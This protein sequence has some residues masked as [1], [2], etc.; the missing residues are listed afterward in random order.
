MATQILDFSE[1]NGLVLCDKP[2][3]AQ[4]SYERLYLFEA[5]K[6]DAYAVFFRRFFKS[7]EDT[8]TYKSEPSVCIFLEKQVPINSQKHLDT[9]AALWSEGK[10][11]I[12]I[13]LKGNTR[14]DIYNVRKPVEKIRGELSLKNLQL[15][16]DSIQSLIEEKFSAK[17][18]GQGTFWEQKDNQHLININKSPYRHLVDYLMKVRKKFSENEEYD[19]N[20]ETIDK[21][22]VLTILVKFLEEK[23][24]LYDDKSTLDEIYSKHSLESIE[25]IQGGF[26][27]LSIIEDMSNEFNGKIFDQFTPDEK[28]SH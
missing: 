23:K 10:V 4:N 17:L 16:S 22:L 11:D 12:Y 14:V 15:A 24:D 8:A 3:N 18:F 6:L 19:L 21:L 1:N 13:I 20:Q 9:H 5:A 7:K 28:S 25:Q 2:E 27:L 26:Q